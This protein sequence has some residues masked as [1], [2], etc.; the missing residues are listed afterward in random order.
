MS[1][2]WLFALLAVPQLQAEPAPPGY[3]PPA[4]PS[5][6]SAGP[7]AGPPD[8]G[9]MWHLSVG[10]RLSVRLG[11]EQPA[12]PTVG[13]GAGVQLGR[14]L[15]VL[16]PIRLGAAFDFGYDRFAHDKA[17]TPMVVYGNYT[18]Y[19]SHAAFAGVVVADALVDRLRLWGAAGAGASIAHYEDPAP[20]AA[21]LVSET[22][23]L[24]V[25]K[26]ATG[27]GWAFEE[28]IEIGLHV[29]LELLFSSVRAGSPPQP[30]FGP[31]IVAFGFDLGLR[32]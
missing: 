29:E 27:A 12:L 13:Y 9:S 11:S 26:L 3:V 32:F 14:V 2:A 24:P 17:S 15:V 25:V 23:I 4:Q 28:R 18:Q 31:G 7:P 5:G 6:P 8:A 20:G 10:A 16:G 19:V 22:D 21:P 1:T 30:L